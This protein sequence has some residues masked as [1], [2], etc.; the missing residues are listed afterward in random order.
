MKNL[1]L[2]MSLFLACTTLF[3]TSC[4]ED[5]PD[6]DPTST[7]NANLQLPS[8]SYT[9]NPDD[10]Q[11][12]NT[13]VV[14]TT[15][16]TMPITTGNQIN[17]QIGFTAPN[18]NVV[19]G[20]MRFGPSGPVNVIPIT[21]AQGQTSGT[22]TMPFT[23]SASTCDNLSSVCHDIKCYEFAITDDGMISQA[24]IRDVA[25]M[26]GNC[27]EPSCVDL[28]DPPCPGATPVYCGNFSGSYASGSGT[29]VCS[30]STL[31]GQV[32]ISADNYVVVTAN[33][34][35]SG[36]YS[37]SPDY[38]TGGCTDCPALQ[39][40]DASGQNAHYAQ[41][42]SGSWNG[43]T[44]SFSATIRPITAEPSFPTYSLSGSVTCN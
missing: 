14:T 17:G 37:F 33:I 24:N 6:G 15:S 11:V 43:N 44:F 2:I 30:P 25:I 10:M 39:I 16:G 4:E 36:S 3:I 20:G 12:D 35:T 19:A 23:L 32:G 5:E 42:G 31:G 29:C 34:G 38:Y 41:S 27:D 28:I 7:V 22:L 1:Y 9:V 40:T 13:V 26:C 18:G 8:G 21:G